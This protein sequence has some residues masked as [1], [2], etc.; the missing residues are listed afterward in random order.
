MVVPDS[1]VKKTVMSRLL[2]LF[3]VLLATPSVFADWRIDAES[4]R[5]SFIASKEARQTEVG[6]FYGLLGGVDDAG[7]VRLKIEL[8]SLRTGVLLQDQ[9]LRK[10]LLDSS[11]FAFAE[12]RS[13]LVLQRLLNLAPGAQME[14]QLPAILSL[15]G[16]EQPLSIELLVTRLDQHRFQVVTLSPVVI[17]LSEFALAEPLEILSSSVGLG[18]VGLAVP[19]SAV[20]IFSEH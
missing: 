14:M 11:R 1:M 4:S 19:V 16:V 18:R 2:V 7:N 5:V 15:H 9:R 3:A 17:D 8:D 10:E 13:E 6:R 12:V 20:L